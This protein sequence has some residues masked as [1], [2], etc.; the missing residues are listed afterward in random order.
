MG[1]FFGRLGWIW[2][3]VCASLA[4]PVFCEE[5][6]R[7]SYAFLADVG[8]GEEAK[9]V[10]VR[11]DTTLST[12]ES[13]QVWLRL[14]TASYVYLIHRGPDGTIQRLIPESFEGKPTAGAEWDIPGPGRWF[15]LDAETGEER[16]YLLASR[17]RL[18]PIE[19]ALKTYE[20][21]PGDKAGIAVLAA[22]RE[23]RKLGVANTTAERPVSMGGGLR[24]ESEGD[25]IAVDVTAESL[26]TWTLTIDHR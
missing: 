17:D 21:D 4:G 14:E 8:K 24:G 2:I 1:K 23:T 7:F 18:R 20:S 25:F 5:D 16:F 13:L 10:S 26:Y 3:W 12:G 19:S 6:V 9:R 15:E 11:Q 22:I